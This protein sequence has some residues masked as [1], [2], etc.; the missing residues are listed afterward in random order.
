MKKII[1]PLIIMGVA[2]SGTRN[3]ASMLGGHK[4][5][6]LQGEIHNAVMNDFFNMIDKL[7]QVQSVDEFRHKK[8]LSKKSQFIL[9][10]FGYM[11][12]GS[13]VKKSSAHYIGHKTPYGERFFHQYEKH[14]NST[15]LEASYFYCARNPLEVWKSL[16]NMPWNKI[17]NVNRFIDD[18]VQSFEM[19]EEIKK[20]AEDRV[21]FFNL[22]NYIIAKSK[23]DFMQENAFDKLDIQLTEENRYLC[24][25]E[26]TNSSMGRVG[27]SPESLSA[28][29]IKIL[30]EDKRIQKILDKYFN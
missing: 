7:D 29:D 13:K 9:E 1:K 2:R 15:G 4:E 11:S 28:E 19:Y 25:V 24:E 16:L 22:N 6:L 17:H 23:V 3:L 18:Y 14:F 12:L 30:N 5:I 21:H 27:K 8:W 20:Q 10:S 26:N